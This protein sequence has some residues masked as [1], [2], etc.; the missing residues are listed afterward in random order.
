MQIDLTLP[1]V[2]ISMIEIKMFILKQQIKYEILI[3]FTCLAA[4]E[5]QQTYKYNIGKISQ[6]IASSP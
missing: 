4:W 6:I 3:C 5:D 1:N 2:T